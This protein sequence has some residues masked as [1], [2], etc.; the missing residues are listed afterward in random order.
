MSRYAYVIHGAYHCSAIV[1]KPEKIAGSPTGTHISPKNIAS[2]APALKYPLASA[3]PA[4]I[5]PKLLIIVKTP[6]SLLSVPQ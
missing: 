3:T 2:K 5:S 1:K 6:A 4:R